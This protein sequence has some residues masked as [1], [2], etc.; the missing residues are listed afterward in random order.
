[1]TFITRWIDFQLEVAICERMA[2]GLTSEGGSTGYNHRQNL[3]Y[4]ATGQSDKFDDK[5][6]YNSMDRVRDS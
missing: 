5:R 2:K 4:V 3:W 1:M 6:P